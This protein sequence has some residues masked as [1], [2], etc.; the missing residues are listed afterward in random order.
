[1]SMLKYLDR[2]ETKVVDNPLPALLRY[3][4]DCHN[5]YVGDGRDINHTGVLTSDSRYI[6]LFHIMESGKLFDRLSLN[7]LVGVIAYFSYHIHG[8]IRKNDSKRGAHSGIRGNLN[9]Y[10]PVRSYHCKFNKRFYYA[11]E[12][13]GTVA[14]FVV[15]ETHRD[16][17]AVFPNGEIIQHS[18]VRLQDVSPY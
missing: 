8:V 1:M 5:T 16:L 14:F 10:K 11:G 7:Q 6:A 4:G 17:Y 3:L 18:S 15:S 9:L 2:V 13:N 12:K